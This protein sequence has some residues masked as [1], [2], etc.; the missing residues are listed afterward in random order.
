[1][2]LVTQYLVRQQNYSNGGPQLPVHILAK[3]Y[4]GTSYEEGI[5]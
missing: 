1:M 4:H 5:S 2:Q 3:S